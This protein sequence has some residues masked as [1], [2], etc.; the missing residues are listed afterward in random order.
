MVVFGEICVYFYLHEFLPFPIKYIVNYQRKENIGKFGVSSLKHFCLWTK[1]C[2]VKFIS[3]LRLIVIKYHQMDMRI[4]CKYSYLGNYYRFIRFKK[5]KKEWKGSQAMLF[6]EYQKY[7]SA[8]WTLLC[9]MVSRKHLRCLI[10][11]KKIWKFIFH[12]SHNKLM[13][14]ANCIFS[15]GVRA[16]AYFTLHIHFCNIWILILPCHLITCMQWYYNILI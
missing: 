15:L 9:I 6:R 1:F 11:T 7:S 14:R 13:N 12:C 16:I 10:P 3:T 4:A 2:T 5:M 8:R